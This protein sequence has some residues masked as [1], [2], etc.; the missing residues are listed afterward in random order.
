M[1]IRQITLLVAALV[2]LAGCAAESGPDPDTSSPTPTVTSTPTPEPANEVVALD[3][4]DFAT[5]VTFFGPG[6]D[7]DSADRNVHC[8]IWDDRQG[9]GL[10]AGC[11]PAEAD[12]QTDPSV[13]NE[14][15]CRGGLLVASD[16]TGPVCDS[17]Q[18]FA[19]EDPSQY[20]VGILNPG[21]SLTYAGI[22]C[23]SPDPSEIEC[24]RLADG[25]GF[26]VGRSDYRY[27]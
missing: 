12:Y 23:T 27:F 3:P 17:G 15:G 2:L 14:V 1:V 11:R 18:A 4:A 9:Y 19:G 24:V 16:P 25:A 10:Y 5:Q 13:L 26:T 8:G 20:A 6:I 22:T 7:F 21:E